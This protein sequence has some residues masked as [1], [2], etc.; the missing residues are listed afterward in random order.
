MSDRF[1]VLP[2]QRRLAYQSY[3]DP[4]GVPAF[5]FHGWPS[6]G[7][8]AVLMDEAGRELGLCIVGVDRPG[9]G[10]SDPLPKRR[11]ADWPSDVAH[12]AKHLSWAKYH[13]FGVSGGGPYVFAT[14]HALPDCVLSASVICGAPPLSLLGTGQLF[15][16]YRGALLL[17]RFVPRL[18]G[19]AFGL[20]LRLSYL[21]PDQWP[22]RLLLY[23]LS[24]ADR[25]AL[26]EATTHQAVVESFRIAVKSGVSGLKMEGDIYTSPWGFDLRDV[27]VPIHLWH[28]QRDRNIPWT[29]S[30]STAELLPRATTHWTPDDGHYSLP[31]LRAKEIAQVAMGSC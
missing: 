8:Q 27:G 22:V 17:R 26:Q 5:F 19:P 9:I 4:A 1:V 6:S 3:G 14:C 31:I 12:L 28:G 20:G 7:S 18:L 16:P 30:E 11:L 10:K 23:S 29:Y 25:R 24:P 15:W 13:L 2:D 21:Q